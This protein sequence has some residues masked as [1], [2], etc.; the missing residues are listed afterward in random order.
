MYT[1]SSHICHIVIPLSHHLSI[2]LSINHN[3][4]TPQYISSSTPPTQKAF[5]QMS[6]LQKPHTKDEEYSERLDAM[7][8][9]VYGN[10]WQINMQ[11]LKSQMKNCQHLFTKPRSDIDLLY[12]LMRFRKTL[13]NV[14]GIVIDAELFVKGM[15]RGFWGEGSEV[16]RGGEGDVVVWI[17]CLSLYG[18]CRS[19]VVCF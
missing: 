7:L 13:Q 12:F 2:H 14:I 16:E 19:L 18:W 1:K 9:D 15:L 10:K 11:E 8:Q 5:S 3:F 17:G 6:Q 4:T